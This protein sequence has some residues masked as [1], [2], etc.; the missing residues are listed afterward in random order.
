MLEY[1][2]GGRLACMQCGFPDLRAL[3][4]DHI[5]G[6]GHKGEQ[7]VGTESIYYWLKTHDFPSG[8]QTLCMNCQS[9]KKIQNGTGKL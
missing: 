2:G 1:Y 4:V 5:N 6:N 9:I 7:K 3:G 8:Y